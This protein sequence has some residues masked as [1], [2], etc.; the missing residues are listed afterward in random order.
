MKER[1]LIIQRDANEESVPLNKEKLIIGRAESCDIV[2]N[3]SEFSREHIAI[4]HKH[5]NVYIEN[6]STGGNVKINGKD[7]EYAELREGAEAAVGPYILKWGYRDVANTVENSNPVIDRSGIK[8][9]SDSQVPEHDLGEVTQPSSSDVDLGIDLPVLESTVQSDSNDLGMSPEIAAAIADDDTVTHLSPAIGMIRITSGEINGREI[10]LEH[11]KEWIVGR[12]RE[13]HVSIDNPKMSR[14]HFKIIQIGSGFRVQD[15]DSSYGIKINGVS[16][17]DAPLKSYD[18]LSA[19][20]IELQFVIVDKNLN[21]IPELSQQL[22][23]LIREEAPNSNSNPIHNERTNYPPAVSGAAPSSFQFSKPSLEN[24]HSQ[25]NFVSV[26]EKAAK[27]LPKDRILVLVYQFKKQPTPRKVL[28]LLLPLLIIAGI[29]STLSPEPSEE[30]PVV[31]ENTDATPAEVPQSTEDNP[32]ES[33]SFT[34]EY[35]LKSAKEKLEIQNL[36]AQAENARDKGDWQK[37]HDLA[38]EIVRRVGKYKRTSEIIAEAQG[39]LTDLQIATLTRSDADAATAAATIKQKVE[40]LLADGETALNEKRWGDAQEIYTNALLMDPK[41]E[42]ATRGQY[43]AQAKDISALGK[44]LAIEREVAQSPEPTP[45]VQVD[46]SAA[47]IELISQEYQAA[48]QRIQEGAFR[49]ALPVLKQIKHQI[50]R[51]IAD[52]ESSRNPAAAI[53]EDKRNMRSKIVESLDLIN[54]QFVLEYK[55]QMDDAQQSIANQK[56]V[57]ARAIYD[58]IIKREPLF[59]EPRVEREKLYKKMIDDGQTA[60]REG[61]VSESVGDLASALELYE[62]AKSYFENINKTEAEEYYS[63]LDKKLKVLRK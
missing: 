49:E 4:H 54:D 51:L 45:E 55:T 60:Y 38:Q 53:S 20:P 34:P 39:Y 56:Y 28:I 17:K 40:A 44:S 11:G 18:T 16:V 43:A 37:A 21:E 7:A 24:S 33:A 30:T 9:F 26:E 61:L 10:K 27:K 19:G 22:P 1:I 3:E 5:D 12:A 13:C 63:I 23:A 36:Y 62:K 50:E 58:T 8:A 15:L 2:W 14:H 42:A 32:A 35:Q 57:E 29:F 41:N 6:I 31:A 47:S 48:K 46:P 52:E 59:D 25:G